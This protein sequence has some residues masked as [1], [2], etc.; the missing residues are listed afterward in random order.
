LF[1]GKEEVLPKRVSDKGDRNVHARYND[2]SA[3]RKKT[4]NRHP[5]YDLGTIY[6]VNP[7]LDC[8]IINE[9]SIPQFYI[10]M[11]IGKSEGQPVSIA[12]DV[13]GGEPHRGTL[14]KCGLAALQFA[15]SIFWPGEVEKDGYL[16]PQA[17]A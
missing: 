6:L 8:A 4:P 1:N 12:F 9:D 14:F 5:A 13:P 11:E 10:F 17:L 15:N 2:T 3:R 16:C 7:E